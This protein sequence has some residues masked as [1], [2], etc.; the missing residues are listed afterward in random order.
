ML[1]PNLLQIKWE[2]CGTSV[3]KRIHEGFESKYLAWGKS[4]VI[5]MIISHH[6]QK[7]DAIYR[8]LWCIL[9]ETH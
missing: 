6:L 7:V 3:L 5:L 2:G 9:K 1:S 8:V 4:V